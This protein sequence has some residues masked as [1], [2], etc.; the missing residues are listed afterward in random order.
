M[1]NEQRGDLLIT[2]TPEQWDVMKSKLQYMIE[3]YVRTGFEMITFLIVDD[4]RFSYQDFRQY[5][6]EAE[7]WDQAGI[8]VMRMQRIKGEVQPRADIEWFVPL[9][10]TLEQA[11]EAGLVDYPGLISGHEN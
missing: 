11:F 7:P 3:N 9:Y 2:L 10:P 1:E 8:L 6:R 4:V 5:L